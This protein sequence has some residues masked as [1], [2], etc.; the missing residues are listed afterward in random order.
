MSKR[1]AWLMARIYALPAWAIVALNVL[2]GMVGIGIGFSLFEYDSNNPLFFIGVFIGAINGAILGVTVANRTQA[3]SMEHISG[4]SLLWAIILGVVY[5]TLVV[6]CLLPITMIATLASIR[7]RR[8]QSVTFLSWMSIL[9][10]LAL[11]GEIESFWVIGAIVGLVVGLE[12]VVLLRPPRHDVTVPESAT[13]YTLEL[14]DQ[15][16]DD[17]AH[18]RLTIGDD[19]ELTE[20]LRDDDPKPDTRESV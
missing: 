2:G 16:A 9:G 18:G 12:F 17:Y 14:N 15:I 13:H 7:Y 10:G 3:L 4:L 5:E 1:E 8:A 11:I 20:S 6:V 19:G